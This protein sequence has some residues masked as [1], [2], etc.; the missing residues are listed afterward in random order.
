VINCT[1]INPVNHKYIVV[2]YRINIQY[3]IVIFT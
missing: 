1:E 3:E 2:V